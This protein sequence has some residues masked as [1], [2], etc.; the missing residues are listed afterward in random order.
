M[1]DLPG[2]LPC[3]VVTGPG[4]LYKE[5]EK[6][7]FSKFAQNEYEIEKDYTVDR[8]WRVWSLRTTDG[9]EVVAKKIF[10]V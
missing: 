6:K 7:V 8:M 2:F 5:S 9:K 3:S 4:L 10:S 1:T